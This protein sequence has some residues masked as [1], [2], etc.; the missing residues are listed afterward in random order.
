MLRGGKAIYFIGCRNSTHN[1]S[2]NYEYKYVRILVLECLIFAT[3]ALTGN[4]SPFQVDSSEIN[5]L[6]Y[7]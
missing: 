2:N 5:D 3:A 7:C 4:N 6:D 1:P